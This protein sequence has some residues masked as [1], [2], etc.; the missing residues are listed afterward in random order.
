MADQKKEIEEVVNVGLEWH[1][2]I[3]L[4]EVEIYRDYQLG[5]FTEDRWDEVIAVMR[6]QLK[7]YLAA[8]QPHMFSFIFENGALD[9]DG[10]VMF[11]ECKQQFSR[12]TF[13]WYARTNGLGLFIVVRRMA[14]GVDR[15]VVFP[16]PSV[17]GT[18]F[19]GFRSKEVYLSLEAAKDSVDPGATLTSWTR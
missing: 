18:S 9:F 3:D 12:A 6:Q 8:F 19:N 11:P 5:R 15:Y 10:N 2:P 4:V 17:S 16:N 13:Y 14:D 7:E 1:R